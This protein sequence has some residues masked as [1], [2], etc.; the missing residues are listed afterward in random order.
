MNKAIFISSLSSLRCYPIEDLLRNNSDITIIASPAIIDH[1]RDYSNDKR[2]LQENKIII[3]LLKILLFLSNITSDLVDIRFFKIMALMLRHK[4]CFYYRKRF[5]VFALR[6][7]LLGHIN[8][9]LNWLINMLCLLF[10]YILKFNETPNV[11]LISNYSDIYSQSLARGFQLRNKKIKL[12]AIVHSWDNTYTKNINLVNFTTLF[13]WGNKQIYDN[14]NHKNF[15]KTKFSIIGVPGLSALVNARSIFSDKFTISIFLSNEK[16]FLN[17]EIYVVKYIE[18]LISVFGIEELC[19]NFEVIIRPHPG[20]KFKDNFIKNYPFV[21]LDDPSIQFI[22]S[23]SF[24]NKNYSSDNDYFFSIKDE[25]NL[26]IKHSDLVITGAS[27]IALQAIIL[28][29]PMINMPSSFISDSSHFSLNFFYFLPHFKFLLIGKFLNRI[30][31]PMDS[32]VYT[33]KV[34]RYKNS[35]LFDDY[36]INYDKI[37]GFYSILE[38]KNALN[39]LEIIFK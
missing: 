27:T 31:C 22:N 21:K 24:E 13:V 2:I 16:I 30:F 14:R 25:A 33:S 37:G 36:F 3:F 9:P 20:D 1:F 7:L 26:L 38:Q 15:S 19:K 5:L 18:S 23:M 17:Q 4:V 35:Y 29:K 12:N 32:A 34:Y 11:F 10:I 39:E 8:K 28:K 6:N